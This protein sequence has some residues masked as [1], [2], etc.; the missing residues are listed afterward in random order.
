[1]VHWYMVHGYIWYIVHCYIWYI[2]TWCTG[3]YGT[4]CTEDSFVMEKYENTVFLKKSDSFLLMFPYKYLKRKETVKSKFKK[5][6]I[7]F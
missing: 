5:N 7:L 2:G 4:L 6:V 3:T 1:M